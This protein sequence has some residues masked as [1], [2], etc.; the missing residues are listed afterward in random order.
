MFNR[1]QFDR[2][3]QFQNSDKPCVS[4]YIPTYRSG[5]AQEDRIRFKNALSDAIQQLSDGSIFY[6]KEMEKNKAIQYLAPAFNLLEDEG[7]WSKLSDGLAVFVGENH[8]SYF[9]APVDFPQTTHVHNHFYL[10]YML[11]LLKDEKRFFV[12]ALSQNEVRFFEG[13]KNSITPVIIKDLLPNG[14]E[15][16]V[17]AE[18][19]TTNLQARGTT[20]NTI[21]YHGHGGGKDDKNESLK[22]YFRNVDNGLMEMLHDEDAPMVIYSVDYQI[23]IYEEISNYSNIHYQHIT[24]NPE[25]DDPVLIHERAWSVV[26]DYFKKK[27][28]TSKKEFNQH[29]VNGKASFSIHEITPAAVQGKVETLFVDLDI[30]YEWGTFDE[31]NFT[32]QTHESRQPDSICLLE[33]TAISTFKNGGNVFSRKRVEMPRI[34]AQVNAVFRY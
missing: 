14:I 4:I 17:G 18:D 34:V 13:N 29:L 26:S 31:K 16:M 7:F 20:S 33:K 21:L 8:F 11:P 19:K 27:N 5:N 12:L 22:K 2:L 24:G 15:E 1:E 6:Q 9:V 32:I 28:E 23:P 25:N 3:H 30:D 10:R